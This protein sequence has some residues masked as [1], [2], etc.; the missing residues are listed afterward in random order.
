M[1]TRV[2]GACELLDEPAPPAELEANLRDI[3][4]LNRLFGGA[5]LIRAQV[6]RLLARVP[7]DRSV[8]ILDVGTGGAD[9]PLALVRWARRRGRRVRI[10]AL[11]RSSQILAVAREFTAGYPEV[12]L[13]QGDGLDLPIKAGAVDVALVSLTLHHLEPAEAAALLSELNRTARFGFIVNDLIRSRL[14]YCLV[15]LGTRLFTRGRMA[16]HDGPLSVLR[17]YAPGEI[18]ELAR[19]AQLN[20]I[21]ITRYPW[22]S[23]IAA[24][25]EKG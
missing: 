23:R 15:W 6:A 21:R 25:A 10:L 22:L 18:L 4:R 12:V 19:Q 8:T 2:A 7:A 11:D 16:R 13:L 9:L 5:W 20:G 24:V 14:A 17:A 3:A 1:L